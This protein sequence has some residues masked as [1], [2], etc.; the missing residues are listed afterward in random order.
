MN[1]DLFKATESLKFAISD[2]KMAI[3]KA[4]APVSVMVA[5][6]LVGRAV[7]LHDDVV[8]L[9]NAIT[10]N[11]PD[12]LLPGPLDTYEGSTHV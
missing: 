12:E 4:D 3:H 8:Q 1:E 11:R 5:V 9:Y 2:L 10:S 7:S 6:K